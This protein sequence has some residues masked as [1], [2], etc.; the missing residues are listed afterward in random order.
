M[1]VNGHLAREFAIAENFQ[2]I[3]EFFD[4]TGRNERLGREVIAIELFER[5]DVQDR[6]FFFE[7]VGEAAL[8]QTAMQ[9][10][11]AAL[12]AAHQAVAR[13]RLRTFGTATRIFTAASTHALPNTLLLVLLA[14]RRPQIAEIHLLFLNN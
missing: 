1:R 3:A 7:D 6:V 9:R 11:L 8:R 14:L 13:D 5:A 4:N 2:T 10:H 12:E